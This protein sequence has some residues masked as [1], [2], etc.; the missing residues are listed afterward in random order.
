MQP[1]ETEPKKRPFIIDD[2]MAADRAR[3]R[4]P[5]LDHRRERE[6]LIGFGP[7]LRDAQ[8]IIICCEQ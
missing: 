8:K 6:A 5:G 3:R 1:P 4:A 7:V 2:E